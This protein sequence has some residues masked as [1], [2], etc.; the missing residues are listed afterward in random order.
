MITKANPHICMHT[1]IHPYSMS[2]TYNGLC[3][4]WYHLFG[5][6]KGWPEQQSEV[7]H[8]GVK[9]DA[10]DF[11]GPGSADQ[12]FS[13]RPSRPMRTEAS[14]YVAGPTAILCRE[15]FLAVTTCPGDPQPFS[16]G[17]MPI[18]KHGRP[19]VLRFTRRVS[20]GP[21]QRLIWSMQPAWMWKGPK[22]NLR[23]LE[24][25]L[26]KLASVLDSYDGSTT[27]A[28][29]ADIGRL[30]Q[31]SWCEVWL[32]LVELRWV[33]IPKRMNWI[34]LKGVERNGCISIDLLTA[35][36]WVCFCVQAARQPR[37]K[38]NKKCM[39]LMIYL[40]LFI[41]THVHT[42][43]HLYTCQSSLG[44]HVN[45]PKYVFECVSV[46]HRIHACS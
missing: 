41:C 3:V 9:L 31:R 37:A 20:P 25:A 4:W 43:T 26:E 42:I 30:S 28:M 1:C 23:G 15:G 6:S 14:H 12:H 40:I 16:E 27:G 33:G 45:I 8:L 24:R 35:S 17:S 29:Q 19:H 36:F 21:L 34:E 39:L 46:V 7:L 13:A 5:A 44:M 38:W 18:A 10:L 22:K 2:H 11:E 32:V